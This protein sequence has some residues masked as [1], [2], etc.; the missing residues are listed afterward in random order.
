MSGRVSLHFVPIS[1]VFIN[2]V[3]HWWHR[4]LVACITTFY[5][6][7]AAVAF[8]DVQQ[9]LMYSLSTHDHIFRAVNYIQRSTVTH[10]C[11]FISSNVMGPRLNVLLCNRCSCRPTH[12]ESILWIIYIGNTHTP[13]DILSVHCD[14]RRC[15]PTARPLCKSDFWGKGSTTIQILDS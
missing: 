15:A 14:H 9:M 8:T 13:I 3:F 6:L 7:M 10:Q 12:W 2:N 4:S 5:P 1:R 11:I